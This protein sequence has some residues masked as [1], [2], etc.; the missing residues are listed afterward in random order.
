MVYSSGENE[1]SFSKTIPSGDSHEKLTFLFS[2]T[3]LT[4]SSFKLLI[5]KAFSIPGIVFSSSPR[6]MLP[7]L[8]FFTIISLYGESFSTASL[9]FFKTKL[10]NNAPFSEIFTEYK[11]VLTV[12]ILVAFYTPLLSEF[13]SQ[14]VLP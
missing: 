2:L 1:N 4:V 12:I 10:L 9:Y 11:G 14:F 7:S 5:Y 8:F 6:I 3:T 13:L